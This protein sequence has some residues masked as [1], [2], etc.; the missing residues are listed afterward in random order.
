VSEIVTNAVRASG[1]IDE[2]Q[3]QATRRRLPTI[4]MWLNANQQGILV[5]VWDGNR[6]M[7]QRQ[8]PS[9]E[10]E[11]GRGLLFVDALCERWGSFAPD[12]WRGKV[13]WES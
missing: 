4:R 10:G 12:G 6:R 11:R 7:P 3:G 8:Q 13:V 2:P 5:Q 1:G 9:L